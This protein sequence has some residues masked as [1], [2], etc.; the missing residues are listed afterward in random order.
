MNQDAKQ[1]LVDAAF[2]STE[3]SEY[4]PFN[5]NDAIPQDEVI[6]MQQCISDMTSTLSKRW[7][8]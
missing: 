2:D 6:D 1:R 8:L 7:R 5:E 4:R 3:P